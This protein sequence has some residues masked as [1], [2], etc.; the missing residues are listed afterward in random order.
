MSHGC[1]SHGRKKK[2]TR[3]FI[4]KARPCLSRKQNRAS[5]RSKKVKTSFFSFQKGTS[6]PLKEEK[7]RL[8]SSVPR[9][10]AISLPEAKLCISMKNNHAS[11]EKKHVFL[12]FF[13]KQQCVVRYIMFQFA[14]TS[15]TTS[16]Y[17]FTC[18]MSTNFAKDQQITTTFSFCIFV[19]K[20]TEANISFYQVTTSFPHLPKNFCFVYKFYRA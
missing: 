7:K 10:T 19:C 14:K 20:Y 15:T 4:S 1:T 13:S 3:F 12:F 2:K 5:H 18:L 17:M 8:F 11:H 9:G 16:V 6:V